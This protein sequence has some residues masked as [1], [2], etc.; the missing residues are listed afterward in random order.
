V[1]DANGVATLAKSYE[2]LAPGGKLVVYGFHSMLPRGGRLNWLA[3]AWN[4]LR[5]P[6]FNP[7]TMTGQNR[8]VM[9]ANLSFLQSHAPTL[10]GGMLWLLERFTSGELVPLPVETWPLKEAAEAQRRIESGETIGKLALI[11]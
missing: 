8:S 10:R 9:A 6:R 1:F 3:L 7:M 4:W 11:P 5:T 2:H